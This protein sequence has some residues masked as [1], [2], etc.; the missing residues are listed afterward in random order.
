MKVHELIAKLQG[1]DPEMR[2]VVSAYEDGFNELNSVV[3][4]RVKPWSPTKQ[5]IE[6]GQTEQPD[7]NGELMDNCGDGEGESVVVLPRRY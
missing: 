6:W 3:V 1:F 5:D 2:V 7:W 4:K